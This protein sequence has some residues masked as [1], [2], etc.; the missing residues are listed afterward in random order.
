MNPKL[1]LAVIIA[2]AGALSGVGGCARMDA[3]NQRSLLVAAGFRAR[4]PQTQRQ[5][6]LFD[7]MPAYRVQR[8]VVDGR[9]FYVFKDERN[10]VAYIGGEAEYQRYQQLAVQQRIANA[11]LMAAQ[12]NRDVARGWYGAWGPRGFR[13]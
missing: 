13:W 11:N 12:M 8:A 1:T 5:R 9:V 10:G 4:T 3:S 2:T 7:A 6:E